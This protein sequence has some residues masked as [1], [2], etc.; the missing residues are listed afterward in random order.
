MSC[1]PA[2]IFTLRSSAT[3]ARAPHSPARTARRDGG[4]PVG[5]G[6]EERQSRLRHDRRR[7]CS[8]PSLLPRGRCQPT[9]ADHDG[10][11]LVVQSGHHLPLPPCR[12]M[13]GYNNQGHGYNKLFTQVRAQS[14]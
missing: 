12:N 2:V 4:A 1:E 6:T 5:T 7:V 8:R 13:M 10:I 14:E 9:T 3:A 11:P